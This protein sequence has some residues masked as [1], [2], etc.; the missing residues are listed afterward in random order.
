MTGI[1]VAGLCG[2]TAA[3]ALMMF[4]APVA[5]QAQTQTFKFDVPAQSLG[6]AL[7]AFGQASRQQIIFSEDVVRGK[8]SPALEGTFTP[9]EGLQRLLAGSGLKVRRTAAGVLYVGRDAAPS[10]AAS[11]AP[12]LSDVSELVVTGSRIRR[13]DTTSSSPVVMLNAEDLTER[14]YTQVGDMLN[15]LTSNT[16]SFAQPPF[17]GIPAGSARLSPTC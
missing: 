4:V 14:G 17:S 2:S 16:P 12:A 7:R 11:T 1:R 10:A 3:A 5:A 9:D 8:E 15:Q 13:T 6:G